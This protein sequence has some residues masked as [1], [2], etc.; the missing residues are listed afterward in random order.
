MELIVDEETLSWIHFCPVCEESDVEPYDAE[1]F[2][3]WA[4]EEERDH[5]NISFEE[6][7]DQEY[8]EPAH[9]HH[10]LLSFQEWADEEKKESAHKHAET[11]EAKSIWKTKAQIKKEL[12]AHKG[13]WGWDGRWLKDY[14]DEWGWE[15]FD[16]WIDNR[17]YGRCLYCCDPEHSSCG[18]ETT[19][20]EEC[21]CCDDT[22]MQLPEQEMDAESFSAEHSVNSPNQRCPEC[23][24][25]GMEYMRLERSPLPVAEWYECPNCSYEFGLGAESWATDNC[26]NC[27]IPDDSGDF[28]ACECD[29]CDCE[30]MVCT[31]CRKIHWYILDPD[32]EADGRTE[33]EW[34]E[35]C[36]DC[37][38]K[39]HNEGI[40]FTVH[41]IGAE[42]FD[43]DYRDWGEGMS[44]KEMAKALSKMSWKE[45]D[46][47]TGY[48]DDLFGWFS[49]WDNKTQR[50]RESY[51]LKELK[52]AYDA[53]SF[54]AEETDPYA[55]NGWKT[56]GV[57]G[58]TIIAAGAAYIWSH[59]KE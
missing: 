24:N 16:E 15:E 2:K 12:L 23:G 14:T 29:N 43:A 48:G 30:Q 46:R 25:K 58:L 54:S 53:E 45:V 32:P 47:N 49:K 18:M 57:I 42:S 56:A 4:D 13:E 51:A 41:P 38:D 20:T 34:I 50:Q 1:S 55:I 6:W 40:G 28:T 7:V 26:S 44:V 35:M 36:E 33:T 27:G 31:E 59:K 17:K 19:E 3:D 21:S 5:G 8:E 10:I 9:K 37:V 52:A 22:R 39:G 11:F